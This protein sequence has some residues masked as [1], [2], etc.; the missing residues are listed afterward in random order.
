[1]LKLPRAGDSD[2]RRPADPT[3]LEN[4]A[5]CPTQSSFRPEARLPLTSRPLRLLASR[6]RLGARAPPP[7]AGGRDF[8]RMSD[9]RFLGSGGG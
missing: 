7:L 3:I 1:M 8:R 2:H 4:M 5:L 6:L 9:G